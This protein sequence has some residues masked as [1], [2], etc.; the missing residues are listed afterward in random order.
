MNLLI[1]QIREEII[2]LSTD[3]T[4]LDKIP[5]TKIANLL[6]NIIDLKN[7]STAKEIEE[8]CSKET[9]FSKRCKG[10]ILKKNINVKSK[11][12]NFFMVSIQK[13]KIVT[14]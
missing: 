8:I 10:Y 11:I 12:F 1:Q 7:I 5:Y 3:K 4:I 6:K 13:R 9:T 2:N 14:E